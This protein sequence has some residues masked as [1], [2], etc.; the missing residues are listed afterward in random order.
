MRRYGLS[1]NEFRPE[2]FTLAEEAPPEDAVID[3]AEAEDDLLDEDA[4]VTPPPGDGS[5]PKR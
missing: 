2:G 1:P 5:E 4:P 3:E